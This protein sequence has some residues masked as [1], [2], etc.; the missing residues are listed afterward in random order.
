MKLNAQPVAAQIALAL[1]PYLDDTDW[2][3]AILPSL[4]RFFLSWF[5]PSADRDSD[6]FPEWRASG[7]SGWAEEDLPWIGE[8]ESPGLAA[9][10]LKEAEAIR[11]LNARIGRSYPAE[12]EAITTRLTGALLQCWDESS[13]LFR[14]RDHET[15]QTAGSE[16][17]VEA[18]KDG[19]Y[20]LKRKFPDPVRLVLKV[21]CGSGLR[22]QLQISLRGNYRGEPYTTE[23][24]SR[25]FT[26]RPGGAVAVARGIFSRLDRMIIR[27]LA[28]GDTLRLETCDSGRQ[29]FS[30]VL[31]VVA[32][33]VPPEISEIIL[34]ETLPGKF[35]FQKGLRAFPGSDQP[36]PIQYCAYLAEGLLAKGERNLAAGI[37]RSLLD[38]LADRLRDRM[39]PAANSLDNTAPIS[40]FLKICGVEAITPREV[41]LN[42][43]NPFPGLVEVRYRN[44]RILLHA[45]KSDVLL[46]QEEPKV[47]TSPE[48]I[49]ISLGHSS[50]RN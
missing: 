34:R 11:M 35:L 8:L 3:V 40:T 23:L 31:P 17:L 6:G 7:Q 14:Y 21:E 47:I 9:M 33:E 20:P 39:L 45:E 4:E 37:F 36:A 18:E 24:K 43:F 25:D 19:N 46:D 27:G 30:L 1:E 13:G 26:W 2:L 15:H 10:L 32:N 48:R 16:I 44:V 42:G 12:M 5:L 41:I 29:D 50:R 22:K 28:E 38:D 49:S